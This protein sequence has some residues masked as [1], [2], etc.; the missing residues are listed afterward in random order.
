MQHRSLDAHAS[1]RNIDH[2]TR[3]I[4]P[5]VLKMAYVKA[6]ITLLSSAFTA[7]Q[8]SLAGAAN[9]T[10]AWRLIVVRP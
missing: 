5:G 3:L 8:N 4:E 1:Y 9:S 7:L 6:F 10:M 2:G